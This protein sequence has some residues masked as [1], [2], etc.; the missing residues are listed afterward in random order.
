MLLADDAKMLGGDR[1]AMPLHRL[2]QPGD[3]GAVDLVDAEEGRQRL[4]RAADIVE[5]LALTRGPGETTKFG[6]ELA[7]RAALAEVA[8]AGD[9]GGKIAL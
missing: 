4:M 6:K 8:V 1:L 5:D 2:E 9:M 7:H 3:A